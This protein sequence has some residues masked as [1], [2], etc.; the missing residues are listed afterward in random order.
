MSMTKESNSKIHDNDNILYGKETNF[1]LKMKKKFTTITLVLIWSFTCQFLVPKSS[2]LLLL[3][4]PYWF[5]PRFQ[6]NNITFLPS[7]HG[8]W[9][10]FYRTLEDRNGWVNGSE[11]DRRSK[12]DGSRVQVVL[13]CRDKGA[14]NPSFEK[15]HGNL[16]FSL[17]T[18]STTSTP[19]R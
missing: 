19:L 13:R 2:N 1:A 3:C 15:L 11:V 10:R 14:M 9:T 16:S 6:C 18:K 12:N 17:F 5:R 8:I 7:N 4:S